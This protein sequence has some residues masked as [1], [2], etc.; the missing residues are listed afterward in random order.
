MCDPLVDAK[1]RFPAQCAAD[2]VRIMAGS[3]NVHR[4]QPAAPVGVD[5][6]ELIPQATEDGYV[7]VVSAAPRR[8]SLIR[9]RGCWVESSEPFSNPM[10]TRMFRR[11]YSSWS[12]AGSKLKTVFL[13]SFEKTSIGISFP[14]FHWRRRFSLRPGTKP[15]HCPLILT[16]RSNGPGGSGTRLEA[17]PGTPFGA[18]PRSVSPLFMAQTSR[19]MAFPDRPLDALNNQ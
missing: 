4:D 13:L 11:R 14:R 10:L 8:A 3:P 16:S 12:G 18:I 19:K 17:H 6:N 5:T 2:H 15:T 9:L 7:S 1:T